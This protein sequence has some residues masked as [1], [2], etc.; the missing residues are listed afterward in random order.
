MEV[1]TAVLVYQEMSAVAFDIVYLTGLSNAS[2]PEKGDGVLSSFPSFVV[3]EGTVERGWMT[4]SGNS[5]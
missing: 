1:E 4:W 5:K 2:D 3:E